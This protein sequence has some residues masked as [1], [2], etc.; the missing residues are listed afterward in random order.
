MQKRAVPQLTPVEEN[1]AT[2]TVTAPKKGTA[3]WDRIVGGGILSRKTAVRYNGFHV[4]DERV[5]S[6]LDEMSHLT[7]KVVNV[8][9]GDRNFVP[10]GGGQ[11]KV[12][13]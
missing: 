3:A 13:T 4:S 7:G 6:A 12:S 8:R 2:I 11:G 1:Q 10:K 5:R 9:S